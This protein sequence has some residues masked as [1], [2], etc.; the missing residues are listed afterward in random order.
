MSRNITDLH[1]VLQQKIS[2]LQK[3][4]KKEGLELGIGECFRSVAEQ[5]ALYAQGRTTPGSIVTNAKGSS[6]SSQHQWGIAF[7]FFKNVKGHAYD[8]TAFFNRVGALAKSIGLGWGGDWTKPVDKP[9][10]YLPDWGKTTSTLK[11]RY[12]TFEKFK[13]TWKVSNETKDN[14]STTKT[15]NN[16]TTTNTTTS[17]TNKNS[18]SISYVVGKTYTL[19]SEMKVRKGAGIKY[20]AKKHWALTRDGQKHDKDGDGALD[21]GT[22]ITCKAVKVDSYGNTWIKT[23]SGWIAAIYNGKIYVK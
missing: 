12:G 16:N 5:N 17:T 15:E 18:S 4:C 19:L 1:P 14:T 20:A 22:K 7:D 13:K 9:H 2:E 8:D 3:L 6:Y 10:V 11:A 21:K 23:P